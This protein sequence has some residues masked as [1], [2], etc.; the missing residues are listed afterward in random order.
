MV[1]I[2][3]KLSKEVLEL[4]EKDKTKKL[5]D[6]IEQSIHDDLVIR[7]DK[8]ILEQTKVRLESKGYTFQDEQ[9]FIEFCLGNIQ[10][11]H[12]DN[13]PDYFELYLGYKGDSDKGTLILFG[14]EDIK[15]QSVNNGKVTYTIG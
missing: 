12:Y 5:T 11:V 4:F 13:K 15:V 8:H 2:Q 14:Q 9:D 10:K 3:Q 7:Y 6:I 1:S